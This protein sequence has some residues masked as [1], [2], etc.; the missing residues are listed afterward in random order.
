MILAWYGYHLSLPKIATA[1]NVR[2][3]GVDLAT[4][5]S[6]FLDRGFGVTIEMWLNDFPNRFIGLSQGVNK[7]LLRWC[8]RRG[9]LVDG[10]IKY[11]KTIPE[12]IERGGVFIPKPVSLR[13]LQEA[14]RRC[15]P[16]ILN[17]DVATVYEYKRAKQKGHFVVPT[18]I[19]DSVTT[20]N[21]PNR[22]YGGIKTYPTERILHASYSW[23]AGAIFIEPR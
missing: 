20:I 8:H 18:H 9:V 7:E 6:F 22:S 10:G 4:L 12:F 3:D 2:A 5:G 23:S 19:T 13:K 15:H 11:R 14:L 16:P 21:D 1:M 17:L